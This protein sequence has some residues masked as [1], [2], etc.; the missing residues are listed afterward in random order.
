MH[1]DSRLIVH[2]FRS[3]KDWSAYHG[4]VRPPVTGF[5]RLADTLCSWRSAFPPKL[6]TED[7]TEVTCEKCRILMRWHAPDPRDFHRL[8]PSPP[9]DIESIGI[10]MKW[11]MAHP[12]EIPDQP[13][14]RVEDV[15]EIAMDEEMIVARLP[16]DPLLEGRALT[17]TMA[18]IDLGRRLRV[19]VTST[20]YPRPGARPCAGSC[21]PDEDGLC[22][23]CDWRA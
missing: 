12:L 10:L 7:D 4:K 16:I 20:G 11:I 17:E 2:R 14:C 1:K 9:D 22:T 18:I 15:L 3:L 19:L 21:D 5:P 23:N 8:A 6:Y 13:T